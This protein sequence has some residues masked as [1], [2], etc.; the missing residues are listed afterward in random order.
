MRR[1]RI[2]LLNGGGSLEAEYLAE[3]RDDDAAIDAVGEQ[4]HR[5]PIALLEGDRLVGR[6]PPLEPAARRLRSGG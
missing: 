3:Y 6:F 1:Y 5:G 2:Q 4:A